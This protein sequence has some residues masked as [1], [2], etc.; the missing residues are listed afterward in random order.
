VA[1]AYVS[2]KQ[3]KD[4]FGASPSLRIGGSQG[5][6]AYLGFRTRAL[7][8]PVGRATLSVYVTSG[9]SAGFKVV[10]T[11]GRAWKERRVTYRSAPRLA[12]AG[13][14]SG[15]VRSGRW[16]NVDVTPLARPGRYV[17]FAVIGLDAKE[18]RVASRESAGHRPRLVVR[19]G[20]DQ[21]SLP[22]RAAFYYP[23]YPE[24][25][26]Q[27]GIS[28]FTR[29]T[30]SLGFY[31]SQSSDVISK[32]VEAMVYGGIQVGLTSWWGRGTRTEERTSK[33]LSVTKAMGSA[34]RWALYYEAEGQGAPSTDQLRADLSYIHE[35]YGRDPSYLR[36]GG[37]FVIFAYGDPRDDCGTT[38]RWK[39]ANTVNAYV[40]L[41]VFPGYRTCKNQP[42]G[43]HQYAP[44]SPEDG[45]LPSSFAISPG[46]NLRTDS[47]PRLDRSLAR[48]ATNIRAMIASKAKFQLVTTFNEWGEGTAVESSR[49]WHTASGYGA[50]LDVLRSDGLGSAPPVQTPPPPPAPPPSPQPPPPPPLPPPAPGDPVIAAV[51][52]IACDPGTAQFNGGN[53][54]ARNC[55]QK[56]TSDLVI[57][58][59]LAA[60]LT[61]GDTQYED[62]AYEK[63]LVSFNPSWGRAKPLI[64]PAIGNHE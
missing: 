44:A 64:R 27:K 43:W 7:S 11:D 57:N 54:T 47:G 60:I 61:L 39:L 5:A 15:A 23:W 37:R 48:W 32:H 51:G 52:D 56:A 9:S 2:S 29:Y 26:K 33:L 24:A 22:V 12:A 58:A 28:P 40:V 21:P 3:P 16:A 59:G 17:T 36:V 62:N 55:R 46:F 35:R 49:Q 45:Q 38:D 30:P 13:P 53:G 20:P 63:Y 31:D 14:L 8:G 50:Y 18:I 42:D 34:F 1:D 19:A 4:N 41:K 25:W 10:A 6:R